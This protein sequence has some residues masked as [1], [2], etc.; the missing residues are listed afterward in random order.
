MTKSNSNSYAGSQV[1]AKKLPDGRSQEAVLVTGA[2]GFI[3]RSLVKKLA[4]K[5]H[6]VV[7]MYRNTIPE[8]TTNVYPVC[9]DLSNVDLLAVPLRGVDTI[10]H[11][12][13]ENTYLGSENLTGGVSDSLRAMT[14]DSWEQNK[15]KDREKGGDFDRGH[16][17]GGSAQYLEKSLPSNLTS[18]K[19]L[20][21]AIEESKAQRLIFVSAIG[22]HRKSEHKFLQE[23]F[24]AE[25]LVINSRIKEKVVLRTSLVYGGETEKL[26][27]F[28]GSIRELL[29]YPAFY[30]VP[31]PKLGLHPTH[32][33]DLVTYLTSFVAE[34]PEG[35]NSLVQ[36][37]GDE[38]ITT[39]DLV[40]LLAQRNAP[41]SK[42]PIKGAIGLS[43]LYI[44]EKSSSH[45]PLN[46]SIRQ[47]LSAESE[48]VFA[49]TK[50]DSRY[51]KISPDRAKRLKEYFGSYK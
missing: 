33:D 13:W 41:N 45:K 10:I 27:P 4:A 48:N 2:S 7:A 38:E 12:A 6:T 20:I 34:K 44:L 51:K 18:L 21:A 32:I 1:K 47:Y 17:Q 25:G 42:V 37:S 26:D 39:E 11:L 9:S 22:C 16:R 36:F 50:E 28:V 40:K 19:N 14:S 31:Y 15:E 35:G 5:G 29:S 43:L 8:T 24:V 23:K 46:P 30:P 49:K 3:G